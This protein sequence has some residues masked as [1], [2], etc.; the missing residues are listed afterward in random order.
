MRTIRSIG[1]AVVLTT[2]LLAAPVVVHAEGEH[3]ATVTVATTSS[4]LTVRVNSYRKIGKVTMVVR[5]AEGRC[6]YREEGKA[7]TDE[8]VRVLDQRSLPKGELTVEV[9]A[10]DLSITQVVAPR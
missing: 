3:L 2:M 6:V 5:D 7:M 8:L 1:S 4:F 9:T 10:R